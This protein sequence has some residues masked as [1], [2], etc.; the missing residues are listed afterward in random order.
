[1]GYGTYGKRSNLSM[2]S[3]NEPEKCIREKRTKI[4]NKKN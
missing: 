3:L 1:M 2:K 4:T